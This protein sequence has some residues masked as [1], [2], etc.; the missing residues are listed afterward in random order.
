MAFSVDEH[1]IAPSPSQWVCVLGRLHIVLEYVPC[2]HIR[3][4]ILGSSVRQ[5]LS[6]VS[7]Q[8]SFRTRCLH[9]CDVD[10]L[11]TQVLAITGSM[12]APHQRLHYSSGFSA[13]RSAKSTGLTP[14][15]S[16]VRAYMSAGRRCSA[17]LSL[18]STAQS[19]RLL[20]GCA[21]WRGAMP[22]YI[23]TLQ[24]GG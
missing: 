2:L 12:Q 19:G 16:T 11:R 18:S 14:Y 21:R 7:C 22:Y 15:H 4:F 9:V 20:P 10:D 5:D 3:D 1:F 6:E 17:P 23:S 13:P 8:V 24:V